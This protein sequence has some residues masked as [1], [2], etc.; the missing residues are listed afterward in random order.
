MRTVRLDAFMPRRLPSVNPAKF[1]SET[2]ELW[3]VPSFDVGA[4]EILK[5]SE[6]GSSKKVVETGDL[7]LSRIVPHIRRAWIVEPS[8]AHRQIGSGEWITFRGEDFH[9][10]YL[11]HILIS[12]RFNAQLMQTIA[13]VGGSLLRARPESVRNIEIPLPPLPEQKRI[14]AILDQADGLRKQRQRALDHLNQLGQSIFYEMFGDRNL[15][16][17]WKYPE[18]E[19]INSCH[20]I[21]DGTHQSPKWEDSGVPFLFSSNIR[22]QRISYETK[23]FIGNDTYA[24]LTRHSPVEKNDV[25]YTAVG[26][27]GHSAVV[28]GKTKFLF[29]RHIAQLKPNF[30]KLNSTFLASFLESIAIKRHAERVAKGVAQKTVTLTEIKKFPLPVVP[31]ETQKEFEMKISSVALAREGMELHSSQ[32]DGCFSSFQQRAFRGE[33]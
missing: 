10:P 23:K 20:K 21:T 9:A 2:F 6:I 16:G 33:L 27:F 31:L 11:R 5:G 7:L 26:S 4:P 15:D 22:N 25:L 18:T 29:Q 12:D 13:G 28:D 19:L 24:E 17:K 32:L 3:S 8:T 1:Q 30:E 14:A